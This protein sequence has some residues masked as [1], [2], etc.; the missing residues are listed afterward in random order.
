V[1]MDGSVHC[2]GN[3]RELFKGIQRHGY[4]ECIRCQR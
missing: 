4:E 2:Q 1:L 3:P